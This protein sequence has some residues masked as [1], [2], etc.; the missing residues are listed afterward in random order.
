MW[1]NQLFI[2]NPINF[3]RRCRSRIII[4]ILFALLGL[5]A[6]ALSFVA[7]ERMPVLYLEPGYRDAIPGFYSGTG[8]GLI[9]AGVITVLRNIRYLKDPELN[10]KRKIY[11]TD[12]RN[13]MLGLRCWA[14][15]GYTMMITLYIGILVSGF[16]S[17]TVL[18]VL[19]TVAAFYAVLLLIF[20]FLL[21][22]A[23]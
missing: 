14:Y 12:E 5:V 2:E 8:V 16:I 18:T 15:T 17:L 4:G 22:R 3:E 13:R 23:M 9:A 6:V 19:M 1:L 20:R 21:Q 10:K 11:E 7:G